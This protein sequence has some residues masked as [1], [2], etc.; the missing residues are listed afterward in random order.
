M[1]TATCTCGRPIKRN[2]LGPWYHVSTGA[3]PCPPSTATPASGTVRRVVPPEVPTTSA[4]QPVDLLGALQD[5]LT[6]ARQDRREQ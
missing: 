1:E 3:P 5:S 2:R 6:R 4:G